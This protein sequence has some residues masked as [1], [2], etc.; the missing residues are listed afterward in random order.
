MKSKCCICGIVANL[1]WIEQSKYFCFDCWSDVW[2]NIG[3][4]IFPTQGRI[5]YAILHVKAAQDKE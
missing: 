5:L 2:D 4:G 1:L 3:T